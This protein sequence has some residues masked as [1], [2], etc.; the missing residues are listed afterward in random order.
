MIKGN[1]LFNAESNKLFE[2]NIW[3]DKNWYYITISYCVL[4]FMILIYLSIIIIETNNNFIQ[5][6]FNI[7]MI[8]LIQI[9]IVNFGRKIT[10]TK[11]LVQN[12]LFKC[13]G[14]ASLIIPIHLE[15][16]TI[17]IW[18]FDIAELSKG[19]NKKIKV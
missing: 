6:G 8:I 12:D 17:K 5:F 11:P 14:I 1:N 18:G 7:C 3:N 10:R 15:S 19:E 2:H 9:W 4:I 16:K 13:F